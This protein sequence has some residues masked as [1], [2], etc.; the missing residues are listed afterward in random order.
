MPSKTIGHRRQ[1]G[2][3]IT[4]GCTH[5]TACAALAESASAMAAAEARMTWMLSMLQK[6]S[7]AFWYC[8]T[9]SVPL[10]TAMFSVA[11]TLPRASKMQNLLNTSS[12][13][14]HSKP[15]KNKI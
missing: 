4:T 8:D 12:S 11:A 1:R 13:H 7:S 9:S 3:E 10:P 5:P 15:M 14:L 2:V 6:I